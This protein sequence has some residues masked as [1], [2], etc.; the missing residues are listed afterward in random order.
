MSGHRSSLLLKEKGNGKMVAWFVEDM[1]GQRKGDVIQRTEQWMRTTTTSWHYTVL[2][3][4]YST[5]LHN[6]QRATHS[7]YGTNVGEEGRVPKNRERE[8]KSHDYQLQM[9]CRKV[10]LEPTYNFSSFPGQHAILV[11]ITNRKESLLWK[12]FFRNV[13]ERLIKLQYG[14]RNWGVI[15]HQE[16]R[17]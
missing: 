13:N 7:D 14:L 12:L 5:V 2:D 11:Y 1:F 17:N 4:L 15:T 8:R 16:A 3:Q 6:K 9:F 10:A